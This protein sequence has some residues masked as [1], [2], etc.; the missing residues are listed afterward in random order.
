MQEA[1]TFDKQYL[2][3]KVT[4]KSV[5]HIAKKVASTDINPFLIEKQAQ[6]K[7]KP[8]HKNNLQ[9]ANSM[10][11]YQFKMHSPFSTLQALA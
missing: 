7:K 10:I 2:A 8:S 5:I 3:I 6:K 9:L 11:Q 1:T 4:T